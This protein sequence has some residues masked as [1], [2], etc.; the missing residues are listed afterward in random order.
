VSA[1]TTD[2]KPDEML[3]EIELPSPKPRTGCCFM[4][5]ARRRGATLRSW[6]WQQ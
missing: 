2:L 4:E 6:V 3:V 5:I 1:L